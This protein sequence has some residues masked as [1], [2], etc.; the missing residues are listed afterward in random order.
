[1]TTVPDLL[2]EYA[3]ALRGDW[4]G[5]DGRTEQYKLDRLAKAMREHGNNPLTD[6][7]VSMLRNYIDVCPNGDGHW[8]E[9]CEFFEE[10]Y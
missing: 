1:M 7:E 10:P 6:A 5:I 9:Y 8:L 2:E 3:E 4:G